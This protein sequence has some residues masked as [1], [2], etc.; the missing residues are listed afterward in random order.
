MPLVSSGGTS[1]VRQNVS[2]I[3]PRHSTKPSSTS[4]LSK[5]KTSPSVQTTRP[6]TARAATIQ[7]RTPD[8]RAASVTTATVAAAS[9]SRRMPAAVTPGSTEIVPQAPGTSSRA[10][11]QP[12]AATG[13]TTSSTPPGSGR[14]CTRP[15]A[16][17]TSGAAACTPRHPSEQAQS[18]MAEAITAST[19]NRVH[20]PVAP[21]QAG[22]TTAAMQSRPIA[23]ATDGGVRSVGFMRDG[24]GRDRGRRCRRRDSR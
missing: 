11:R 18:T 23:T 21:R 10:A 22:A 13:A 15:T 6:D 7:P 9:T 12:A 14:I 2:S 1:V 17:I 5:G 16:A 24:S 8:R 3:G 20:G 4:R 19:P